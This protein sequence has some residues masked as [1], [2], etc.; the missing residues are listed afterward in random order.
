MGISGHTAA[1]VHGHI[2]VYNVYYRY[3]HGYIM[4]IHEP[5]WAYWGIQVCFNICLNIQKVKYTIIR[6]T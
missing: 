3:V 1:Y 6:D 4:G 2:W 5:I